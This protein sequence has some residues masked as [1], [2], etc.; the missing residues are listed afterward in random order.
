M[1]KNR[2]RNRWGKS[3]SAHGCHN[4]RFMRCLGTVDR[5]RVFGNSV[6]NSP[7]SFNLVLIALSIFLSDELFARIVLILTLIERWWILDRRRN[8]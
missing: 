5:S 8:Q 1:A 6:I 3:T 4:N 2:K 7:A